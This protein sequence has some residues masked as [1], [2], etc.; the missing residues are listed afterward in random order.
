M[1]VARLRAPW[2]VSGEPSRVTVLRPGP[3]P[4]IVKPSTRFSSER[5]PATPGRR[6]ATSAAFMFGKFPNESIATIF[7]TFSALRCA[8]MAAA[9]PSR[10]PVTLKASSL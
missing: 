6:M 1:F 2:L 8:V 3:I 4:R 9:P 10:S 7:F 5:L